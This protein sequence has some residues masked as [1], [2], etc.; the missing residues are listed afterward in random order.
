M[1]VTA[2][3]YPRYL[4]LIVFDRVPWPRPSI[5][6]RAC[7]A[8]TRSKYDDLIA[9]LRLKQAYGR[10]IRRAT[11][12]GVFI[13]LDPMMPSRLA[14]FSRRH[15]NRTGGAERC[16]HYYKGIPVGKINTSWFTPLQR[17]TN[18]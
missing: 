2:L 9:R 7:K 8:F 11:D 14:G 4:Q 16:H 5:L 17:P 6:H 1:P 18:Q 10:L 3:M 15:R 12:V 13:M